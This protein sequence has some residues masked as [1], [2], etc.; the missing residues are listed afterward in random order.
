MSNSRYKNERRIL[1]SAES[2][3][4]NICDTHRS[5]STQDTNDPGF[6]I[7]TGKSLQKTLESIQLPTQPLKP[8][9][10]DAM[11]VVDLKNSLNNYEIITFGRPQS[12]SKA[13]EQDQSSDVGEEDLLNERCFPKSRFHQD[14][15]NSL[16]RQVSQ[17][18]SGQNEYQQ[19]A[20]IRAHSSMLPK[21]FIMQFRKEAGFL[22][23]TKNDALKSLNQTCDDGVEGPSPKYSLL[24]KQ[25]STATSV[26]PLSEQTPPSFKE[27]RGLHLNL[28][29]V[30]EQTKIAD[31]ELL[32]EPIFRHHRS[33]SNGRLN[34]DENFLPSPHFVN[35]SSNQ[36]HFTRFSSESV[37]DEEIPEETHSESQ[38]HTESIPDF[39][40]K[41][42]KVIKCHFTRSKQASRIFVEE[43]PDL[44]SINSPTNFS[45]LK[46]CRSRI[47]SKGGLLIEIPE[48]K[49]R[50]DMIYV[51][52]EKIAESF[53]D[54]A[55]SGNRP[56]PGKFDGG[57][58]L[59]NI[60]RKMSKTP[61]LYR[62][63]ISSSQINTALKERALQ[64]KLHSKA[65]SGM[66]ED[67]LSEAKSLFS[68]M[69]EM[70]MKSRI[71]AA[72]SGRQTINR[73][74]SGI[75]KFSKSRD[76]SLQKIIEQ[77][78]KVAITEEKQEQ[79]MPKVEV[80]CGGYLKCSKLWTLSLAAFVVFC[81]EALRLL[82]AHYTPHT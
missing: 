21:E 76:S 38:E 52:P 41:F 30:G 74:Q 26:Q 73:S 75:V 53:R 10:L 32:E 49:E 66:A 68:E 79:S 82:H 45:R 15:P 5:Q 61:L 72:T 28:I 78:P 55:M 54:F 62:G 7:L 22:T 13:S 42:R 56:K 16:K 51:S 4:Y 2:N 63:N 60:K 48:I 59:E 24:I 8:E 70:R 31:A 80:E 67:S 19:V 12:S 25:S 34:S 17:E 36:P 71:E 46:F 23:D 64:I 44:P 29:S 65:E 6:P 57:I 9:H 27:K 1:R 35:W 69:S 18:T 81:V 58:I 3:I 33:G 11:T 20:G 77:P 50:T 47:N 37:I 14:P 39:S 40:R 43:D